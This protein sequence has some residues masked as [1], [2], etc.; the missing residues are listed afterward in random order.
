M[1]DVFLKRYIIIGSILS[2]AVALVFSLGFPEVSSVPLLI[3]PVLFTVVS[4]LIIKILANPKFSVLLKFSNA[5]ML[6]NML[7]MLVL[8]VYFVVSYLCIGQPQ[9][10]TFVVSF[11]IMYFLYI[12]MD[13]I[14][15][16]QFFKDKTQ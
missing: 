9:K 16:L 1:V 5:F 13:T 7:K 15:L 10:I 2:I 3:S 11:M 6:T 4:I 12:V 14:A 8:L